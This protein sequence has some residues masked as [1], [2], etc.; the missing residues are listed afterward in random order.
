MLHLVYSN[1]FE[2]LTSALVET[3]AAARRDGVID[4]LAAPPILVPNAHIATAVKLAFARDA[5]IAAGLA[6]P[7]AEGCFSRCIAGARPD[8]GVLD[9]AKLQILVYD[10]LADP[11]LVGEA[12]MSP[13]RAYLDAAGGDAGARSVRGIQLASQLAGL[14]VDYAIYRPELFR[15]WSRGELALAGSEHNATETWQRRLWDA[16]TAGSDGLGV[17]AEEGGVTWMLLPHIFETFSPA[18]LG[19][20]PVFYA[21]GYSHLSPGYQA[22]FARAAE[23]SELHIFALNPCMEYWEDLPSEGELRASRRRAGKHGRPPRAATLDAASDP[24]ALRLWGRPGRETVRMLDEISDCDFEPRFVD[25]TE[26]LDGPPPALRALQRDMLTRSAERGGDAPPPAAT[27]H[28]IRVLACPS[29]RREL[30]II[31]EEIRRL[32][33]EDPGLRYNDIAIL[34]ARSAQESYQAHARAVFHELGDVPHHVVDRPLS[35]ESR[36]AEALELLLDLPLGRFTRPELLRVLTHPA[37]LAGDADADPQAWIRWADRLGI[38]HGADRRDHAAT[39]IDHDAFHW[40][41]ALRRLA[42]GSVMTGPR[43]GDDRAVELAGSR[44]LPE[45]LRGEQV[46]SAARLVA[47]ARSLIADARTAQTASMP[48]A[49]WRRFFDALATSYLHPQSDGDDRHLETCRAALAGL[50]DIDLCGRPVDFPAARELAR[51]ALDSLRTSRGALFADGVLVAPLSPMRPLP[52]RV[53]FVAGLGQGQFPSGQKDSPLD[54]RGAEARRGDVT[55][56]ERDRYSF[57]EALLSARDRF[58]ASYVA[59]DEESGEQLAPSSV[60][61]ELVEM[62]EGVYRPPDAPPITTSFPLRGYDP[63]CAPDIYALAGEGTRDAALGGASS[64]FS[65]A[66]RSQAGARALRRHLDRYTAQASAG[67]NAAPPSPDAIRAA[68][69]RPG[70]DALKERFRMR[71]QADRAR[72]P[73]NPGRARPLSVGLLYRFLSD[74]L[75]AWARA[76]LR[77]R[78]DDDGDLMM[79]EDEPFSVDPAGRAALLRGAFG[80]FLRAGG[81]RG[82]GDGLARAYDEEWERLGRAGLAPVG[83]F[84]EAERAQHYQTLEAWHSAAAEACPAGVPRAAAPHIGGASEGETPHRTLPALVLR[85][86]GDDAARL[87][88]SGAAIAGEATDLTEISIEGKTTQLV[89]DGG[90]TLFILDT[91]KNPRDDMFLRGLLDHALLSAAELGSGAERLLVHLNA[92][93]ARSYRLA[94]FS[95]DEARAYLSRLAL[96]LLGQSHVYLLPGKDALSALRQRSKAPLAQRI[97][98]ARDRGTL[99]EEFG[100]IKRLH[101]FEPPDDPEDLAR[102][103]LGPLFDKAEALS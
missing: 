4:P 16:L 17:V 90:E 30:E 83:L 96:E 53:V 31:G 79:L 18:E 92:R 6:F 91:A 43:S 69:A 25:P 40:D 14:Y 75:Q 70:R 26:G 59:R 15:A 50:E 58:Y 103:R 24:P 49:A 52:Y 45:E 97:R 86:C 63:R 12:E 47:L 34:V 48:L 71:A 65:P 66:A 29:A 38:A 101:R 84:S 19:L 77:L 100:V 42:L 64:P 20:P 67:Q 95:A 37:V 35:A 82:G 60:V 78:D 102:R 36:Y 61:A 54:L 2:E 57:L 33:Q 80:S 7:F 5:G 23:V 56:R 3:I 32:T 11:A 94:P 51:G 93:R 98:A 27:D 1:R 39:Y 55:A 8:I 73:A 72:R 88:D 89:S 68:L 81:D 87:P 21:I 41:Q 74:P 22:V 46:T 9:R 44:L 62:I 13:V 10:A 76:V 99:G 28:S 85:P